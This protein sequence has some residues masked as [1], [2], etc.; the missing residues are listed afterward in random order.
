[1][2]EVLYGL[3]N[4]NIISGKDIY[5]LK[6]YI[7]IKYPN[8]TSKEHSVILANAVHKIIDT[9][10]HTFNEKYRKDIQYGVLQ[11]AV[12]NND[13]SISAYE[14]LC[15]CIEMNEDNEAFQ[16]SLV[17]WI[18]E[19][20]S[21]NISC[22]DLHYLV[23]EVKSFEFKSNDV[24]DEGQTLDYIDS[25]APSAELIKD[26]S[27][28][29]YKTIDIK[30]YINSILKSI[31]F[32][33]QSDYKK[34]ALIWALV[35]ILIYLPIFKM[36][37]ASSEVRGYNQVNNSQITDSLLEPFYK[38]KPSVDLEYVEVDRD[39]LK[40]WLVGKKSLLT[41]E[42]YFSS[43]LNAAKE[44][45][46]NPLLM[47]SITGQEQSFVP[48]DSKNAAKIANN[49][50]NVYGSWT[51]YNTN[52]NDSAKI[53]AKTLAASIKKMPA[54]V[55]PIQWINTTYAEDKNWWKGTKWFLEQ[56]TEKC[57]PYDE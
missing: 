12:K 52:I 18:N 4:N 37:K 23:D 29:G 48:R 43:I 38:N 15:Q 51:I 30:G 27:S 49:P 17:N 20:Q 11:K 26:Y 35:A 55:D 32:T 6:Q 47:I 45:N 33:L 21:I 1:M 9:N 8:T 39:K 5:N 3:N 10:I 44:Y 36:Q 41:D 31:L 56:L 25:V 7:I 19:N 46:V 13:F 40:K 57:L 53:A 54:N 14:V 2:K 42:P 16:S 22:S 24:I 28:T 50:F 34:A